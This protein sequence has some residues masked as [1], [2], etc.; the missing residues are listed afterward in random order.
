MS[1]QEAALLL[2]QLKQRIA[3][4][5]YHYYVLDAP[6]VSDNEYD[7]IYRQLLEIERQYPELITIDSPS[8]RIGGQAVS[9]FDSVKHRQ[10]MLSLNNAFSDQELEAFDRRV[11]EGTGESQVEY[12]VEPKFDGLAITLTY[13]HG[14]F[15]QGATRGDGYTGENVTHNLKTIRAIPSCLN[16]ANP[17]TLLEVR[18]EVLMLKK[19]F[20]KL[21]QQQASVGGKL[22]ANPRNAAAG[23]LRQLDPNITAK[24]PLHFFAYGLGASDG[25]PDLHSHAEAMQYL[26]NLRFPVSTLRGLKTGAQGLRDYYV[27]IGEKRSSLP[28]DIDGVVYK[29]NAFELQDVLGFVSRAPRWA[30]AHKFPAEE[31]ITLVEDITVQVGRTGAITPVARLKPVFV[32]G[33]TVT[34]ATLHNEDEMRRK[35][36]HI[37]D[38]VVVRRAGDVIPEV[39]LVKHEL[40]PADAHLFVMPAVCPECGSHV[41]RLEDEAVARCTGGLI[42]PAQRKQAITHFASRRAMDIEGLGEKLVDQLVERNLVHHLDDVYRLNL[43]MLA[44][45]DRMAEKS[46]QNV[47]SAIEKSKTTTLPRFIYALGIRNV[48]EATAKDLAQHFGSLEALMQASVESLMQVHDVGPVVAEATFQFFDEPHNREVIAAMRAQGVQWA[49]IAKTSTSTAFTGKTFV[50]TGT[51]PTLKRD[52]AQAMIEAAGGKVSGSVSAKTSYVVAG[53]E[54]GSKLEKAQQL[55]IPILE[56]SALLEMLQPLKNSEKK[57]SEASSK[58]PDLF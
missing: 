6:L 14:V 30:V 55:N 52:Q 46:A 7:G 49:D 42:C 37:G 1:A 16:I 40:R 58:Q 48:G 24:R 33:V 15:V 54:A 45:L 8:Q 23:S 28:F 27:E 9:A 11:R 34:N 41:V 44:G 38:T 39:V 10:A 29:V 43:P 47:L 57:P 12:A 4:Y 36:I 3:E 26:T 31:A 51:L 25:T 19:D 17:P 22:F 5:D 56:E 53:A 13:E 50:L 21:N 18:G 32:G 35:D 2:Q 20:E